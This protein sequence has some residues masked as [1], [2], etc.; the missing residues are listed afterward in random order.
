M[1]TAD[2]DRKDDSLSSRIRDYYMGLTISKKILLGYMIMAFLLIVTSLFTLLSLKRLNSLQQSI[3]LE[4]IKIS[5]LSE[6]LS[7]IMVKEELYGRRYAILAVPEMLEIFVKSVDEAKETIRALAQLNAGA[8]GLIT[9]HNEFEN[10]F[11]KYFKYSK[12]LFSPEARKLDA[13]IKRKHQ[14]MEELVSKIYSESK[15]S[16][17]EKISKGSQISLAAYRIA[18]ALCITGLFLGLVSGLFITRNISFSIDKLKRATREVA[19]GKFDYIPEI[20]SRDELGELADAFSEMA[21]KLKKLEEMY[22]DASPLTRLP[23]GVAIENVLR[24]RINSKAPLAFCLV[25]MDNFKAFND[26]YGYAKGS[27]VIKMLGRIVENAVEK[28]DGEGGFVGH[29]GGDDFVVITRPDTYHRI[30]SEI[31]AEFDKKIIDFYDAEDLKMGYIIGKTRQGVEMKFPIM[32][33]SIAVVTNQQRELYD[34]V[35]VGEIAAE[36][37]EYAKSM[38]GSLYVVDKRRRDLR[39]APDSDNIIRFPARDTD[40]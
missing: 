28:Y 38:Q 33:V 21:K 16:Q 15:L 7:S 29:V 40:A 3:L 5:E 35:Q 19:E 12:N 31:I 25:D 1:E 6:R 22:L 30:C 36:L 10:L 37:K 23:G 11:L 2:P 20:K 8:Q 17:R 32:T 18:G 39:Q 13:L 9:L 27:E 14:E 24:K 34:P 26:R 4:D